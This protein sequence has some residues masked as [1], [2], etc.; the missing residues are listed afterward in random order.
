MWK[1]PPIELN[2]LPREPGVYRMLDARRKVLYIGKARS[3]RKRV[4]SYFQRRP[5][6]PRTQS[7]LSQ[8]RDIN[9]SVSASEAEALVLE[10]NL[11]KQ[12]KPR[13][14]VLLKDAKSYPYILL[15]DADYP[16]LKL[17]RGNRAEAGE[18][19]GPFPNAGAVHATLHVMQKVFRIRDCEDAVFSHRSRP[20]MQHQ[21]GRCSAPCCHVVSDQA[22]AAQ[23]EEARAF[24]HGKDQQLLAAWEGEMQTASARLDFEQAALLRDRIH[25]LRTVLAGSDAS[26]LPDDADAIVILRHAGGVAACIGVRRSGRDLGVHSVRVDQAQEADDVEILQSLLI[27]RYQAE[28]P[29]ADILLRVSQAEADELQRLVRLLQGRRKVGVGSPKRGARH[30]WLQQIRHAGEQNLAARG[31]TDQQ[32]A[33]EALAGLLGMAE[34]PQCIAAVD[35][36]HLGGKQMVAAIVFAN[37]SG[38][39]KDNYRRYKLDDVPPGDDYAGMEKVLSRFFRAIGEGTIPEPDLLLIDG[40]KGQLSVAMKT[41]ADGGLS[42]MPLLGVAKGASRKLGEETLWPG[43]HGEDMNIGAPLKP[44]RHSPA[45]LLIARIR[46]EAHRFAGQYMRKRKKKSM[47]T[48]ALDGIP[49]IGPAKRTALLRHFGGIQGVKKASREQLS[50]SPGVSAKLAER[51]FTVLHQ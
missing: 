13:Y 25:A 33:F 22:Y 15:T 23:V 44:G 24:L 17:Y 10:H 49:G 14:N 42:S 11:I 19:F 29:P 2:S 27:E 46:D 40:G 3:L 18:Y 41:A 8:V 30:Q 37:W 43:W 26:G 9:I 34:T 36:A 39:D 4:S 35:N 1:Q 16:R 38:P 51:I 31:R 6:S 5:D 12:L 48:S 28:Q 20:C 45:L 47:F 32:P 50:R 7:M 21:I